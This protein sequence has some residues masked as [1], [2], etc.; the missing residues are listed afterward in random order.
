MFPTD[1]SLR[2]DKGASSTHSSSLF[3][4]LRLRG[5]EAWKQVTLFPCI[6]AVCRIPAQAQSAYPVRGQASA[7]TGGAQ[8]RA[9]AFLLGRHAFLPVSQVF[10]DRLHQLCRVKRLRQIFC[11]TG[12]AATHPVKKTVFPTQHNN[13]NL[14][15]L[16]LF[17]DNLANMVPIHAGK[18][19]IE[20]N[21][22]GHFVGYRGECA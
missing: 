22:G 19:D 2:T 10:L 17:A 18:L 7:T 15:K 6:T 8:T 12:E 20:E 13:G 11:R 16:Q 3:P 1:T 4:F 9:H 5:E 21:H 14:S